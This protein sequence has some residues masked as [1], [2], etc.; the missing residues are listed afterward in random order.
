M[1]ILNRI[2]IF[3]LFCLVILASYSQSKFGAGQYSLPSGADKDDYIEKTII[4]KLSEEFAG[5]WNINNVNSPL[6]KALENIK[7]TE[8]YQKFPGHTPPVREKDQWGRTLVDLSRIYE[9]KFSIDINIE[10]AINQLLSSGMLEYAQPVFIQKPLSYIPN[11]PLKGPQYSIFRVN[12][13]DAWGIEKGDTNVVICISDWGTDIDHPDLV[14]NIKYNYNDP[15]DGTDNDNDGY[16]DNYRGWDIGENDNN[17]QGDISHGAF[18]SGLASAST[19]NS[20]GICGIGFK[21]KFLP[22][23]IANSSGESWVGYESM[24]YAADHGSS[25]INCSWGSTLYGGQYEQDIIDYVANNKDAVIIAACGNDN[26]MTPY[27]P[28]SYNNVISVAATDINDEKWSYDSETGSNYGY[29]VD[30]CSPGNNIYSTIDGG[31]YGYGGSGTSY[32]TPIVSGAAALVRSHYP[33]LNSSQ[34]ATLLKATCDIIDT[35]TANQPYTGLLGAGRLNIYSALTDTVKSG[36]E[37]TNITFSNNN[38]S[39]NFSPS[40]TVYIKGDFRNQLNPSDASLCATLSCLST[41]ITIIDSVFCPG[42]INTLETVSNNS[43]PYIFHIESDVPLSSEVIFKLT[44]SDS[45]SISVQ[46]FSLVVNQGYLTIDTNSVALTVCSKGMLG[47]N[48]GNFTQGVGFKYNNGKTL[49]SSGGLLAGVSSAQVSDATYGSSGGYSFDFYPITNIFKINPA[50]QSDF[51]TFCIFN[52]SLAG[53]SKLDI[54]IKLKTYTW[55]AEERSKFI[56]LDY[57]IVNESSNTYSDFYTGLYSDFDINNYYENTCYYDNSIQTIYTYSIHGGPYA[58]IKLLTSG[59]IY[60]YAFDNNGANYSI[61]I[62]DGFSTLEKYT[63]LHSTRNQS[64]VY[65]FGNDVS[66]M[67]STGP[68]TIASGDS[69]NVSFAFLAADHYSD[70]TYVA[71]SA[72][73]AYSEI[74]ALNNNVNNSD[75]YAN[76]TIAPNPVYSSAIININSVEE[77][78]LKI[79]VSSITGGTVHLETSKI[80]KAGFQTIELDLEKLNS[81]IYFINFETSSKK[82]TKKL[83]KM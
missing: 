11:D 32:A 43:S 27:Y 59:N 77:S 61:S 36:V 83:I 49:I 18:V 46:Y 4:F 69:I 79:S 1:K 73:N 22:L 29:Y 33:E 76:I 53:A 19:D 39:I 8:V 28:A 51:E 20:T 75:N 50:T 9:C 41:Y 2:I 5:T 67:I 34:V 55:V 6:T 17:P 44:I 70:L 66:S 56:I 12:A 30:I 3:K 82:I 68:F 14:N 16:I 7:F 52:D 42:V 38:Q 60:R 63:S 58:G 74:T 72:Q 10:S 26:N 13:P 24:I 35:I 37:F 47:F 31:T 54:L 21:C 45:N 25:I 80:I 71:N 48:N 64:G 23:K 62:N 57:T 15:I 65:G 78:T 40:D 81:G